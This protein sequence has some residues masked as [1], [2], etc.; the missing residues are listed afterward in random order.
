MNIQTKL[1]LHK[2]NM[3]QTCVRWRADW[4]PLQLSPVEGG[5]SDRKIR[6]SE[7]VSD[8]EK[9]DTLLK[10]SIGLDNEYGKLEDTPATHIKETQGQ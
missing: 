2:T 1:V 10:Q 7:M 9:K 8:Q 3:E 6:Q 4:L 5:M